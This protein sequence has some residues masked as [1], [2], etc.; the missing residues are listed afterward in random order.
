M[1]AAQPLPTELQPEATALEPLHALLERL[2]RLS[3]EKHFDA[4]ADIAWNDPEFAV[5]PDDLRWE[6]LP[7]DP[8]YHTAWYRALTPQVRAQIGLY[9][10]CAAMKT[11]WQFEN[12]LQRGLLE[13]VTTLPN[14]SPE[15]RYVHHEIIEESQHT[16]MFQELVDRSR[17]P[18]RGLAAIWRFLALVLVLPASRLSPPLFF[19]FVLGGED[20]IDHLQRQLLQAGLKHPLAARIMRIHVTEEARHLSFAREFLRREVPKLHPLRQKALSVA[21]P[22]LLGIMTRLMLQPPREL[23][24]RFRMPRAVAQEVR[25]STHGRAL[26][27]DSVAKPRQLCEDLGLMN[28]LSRQIWRAFGMQA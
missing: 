16:L 3:V 26:Q 14:Q 7:V 1:V 24:Q 4:Y 25:T 23:Q 20:P 18:I 10:L 11:G 12:V 13:F 15:F 2:S 28:P 9:R 17:L 19:F 27:R 6:L 8:L 22:L 5:D 21:V